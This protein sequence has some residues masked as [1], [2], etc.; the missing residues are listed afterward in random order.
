MKV[1]TC[2]TR[3][4]LHEKAAADKG[5]R[6]TTMTFVFGTLISMCSIAQYED[7]ASIKAC[8]Q[9]RKPPDIYHQH[10]PIPSAACAESVSQEQEPQSPNSN[11]SHQ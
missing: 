10:R 9:V 8:N 7:N 3:L 11:A 4:P 5:T 6:E 2:S 1:E